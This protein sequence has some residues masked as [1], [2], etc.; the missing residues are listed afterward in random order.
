MFN[1][2]KIVAI[3]ICLILVTASIPVYAET[4]GSIN[5]KAN[6]EAFNGEIYVIVSYDKDKQKLALLTQDNKFKYTLDKL[7]AGNYDV[8]D[9]QVYKINES[10]KTRESMIANYTLNTGNL[11]LNE[12]NQN[13]SIT[14]DIHSLKS[15]KQNKVDTN[16]DKSEV[17]TASNENTE[18]NKEDNKKNEAIKA[19]EK[20]SANKSLE[21]RKKLSF[22]NFI[23]DAILIISLGSVWFFK[24]R[25]K[26]GKEKDEK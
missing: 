18:T 8:K 23:I 12:K 14:I 3:S 25:V 24:V 6:I 13:S 9:I 15:S 10:D 5:I 11:N 4:T 16:S 20:V 21:K 19:T 26:K 22:Y 1:V 17:N 7:D 2:K